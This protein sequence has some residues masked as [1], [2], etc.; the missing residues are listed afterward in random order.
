MFPSGKLPII[1]LFVITVSLLLAGGCA[2]QDLYDPPGASVERVGTLHLP[3]VNEGVAVMGRYAFVAGGQAGLHAIDFSDPAHPVLLQTI[4]TLKYSES[5]EVVR[6]FVDHT[7][8]D[9]A[10]VVEGTE[11]VT[12][13]DITDPSN[14]ISFN[15]TT[16]AVFGNRI[17][18][19]QK[20]DPQI[21][22]N[23]Y[24]AEGWKGLRIFESIPNQPGILNYNGVF[25]PTNG[26][27]EGVFAKDGFCYVADDEMGL[28]VLD[29]RV[30]EL[31]SVELVSWC[32]SPGEAL[33]VVIQGQFAYVADGNEGLAIFSIN[34]G[35]TPIRIS[36]ISLEGKCRAI[37]VRDGVAILA[38]QSS[39]VNF[40]DVNDPHNP[41][42]L[43]RI[44]TEY[45]MDLTL[46]SEGFVLVVDR[47]EGLI[48][49]Q[50]PHEFIDNTPPARVT[51]LTSGPFGEQ[52]IRLQWYMT[53]DDRME[54]IAA[55][56]DIRM[57]DAPITDETTWEAAT[58]L[59][60]L[61]EPEKPGSLL[62]HV[63]TGLE[64][65]QTRHFAM[66]VSDETGATT[67]LSNGTS[68]A[69]GE[70]IFLADASLD[71][72]GG[73]TSDT[74]T[75]EISYVY[76][77]APSVHQVVIDGTGHEMTA[78]TNLSGETLYR[79][80]TQLPAGYH[81]YYFNFEATGSDPIATS[82]TPGPVVGHL[83]FSMGST[84]EIDPA[85]DLDEW[86]HTVVLSNDITSQVYELS[87]Q[88]WQD[89]GLTNPSHF[90]SSDNPVETITW[91]Q[92][93]EACNLQSSADG[94]TPVY[95]IDGNSVT[96]NQTTDGWRLPTEAEW[97][98]LCR[99]GTTTSFPGG[100][101]TARVCN[102]DP[103][104]SPMAWYC[105]SFASIE[106]AP[107]PVGQKIN[108]PGGLHDITG[109]VW[110]WCWD[111]YGEYRVQDT[112]GDGVV[113]DPLGPTVGTQRVIRG[114]SWYTGTESCRSANRDKRYPDTSDDTIGLRMVR[115]IFID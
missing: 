74:Y 80:Q 34:G 57:S 61:P 93:I 22:Y 8:Q 98:F 40:V 105:G 48:I 106:P 24:M 32:D 29:V 19:E 95:T 111:W 26:Y 15:T 9:V 76:P 64:G 68:S 51:S 42:F 63:I 104:L 97:E 81:N 54:G 5:V 100:D 28:A 43:G 35:E 96:W 41:I 115:S 37:A 114:G 36:Q 94:R 102:E 92:A 21:P 67:S 103:V 27:G 18:V 16:T 89:L 39:G 110:E 70:G 101:L 86:Q 13:Y 107:Q 113:L 87:Q 55:S 108:N 6:T 1:S 62:S 69:P 73:T 53:G 4:N 47:D 58:V 31:G 66:K 2:K 84:E 75:Y 20:E 23:V 85:R 65:T 44:D 83:A 7:L 99:A 71:I 77:S 25:S 91:L 49:F 59:Q 12:S 14:M 78:V 45:A 79:Y 52:S 33:D 17:F 56:L 38:A 60:N 50:S 46:S 30:L 72:K 90:P 3:S 82:E 112:D 11:G 10:L 88:M 109:N